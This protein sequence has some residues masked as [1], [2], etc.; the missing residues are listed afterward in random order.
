MIKSQTI[1]A[2]LGLA[3]LAAGLMAGAAPSSAQTGNPAQDTP[4]DA[5]SRNL[6]SLSENPKSIVALMG[7]GKAALDLGDAQ[8][9]ITF[10]GRAEEQAPR[11][12]RV[13]MWLG[14][15]LVQ[16]Q[17]AQ[18]ALKFFAEAISLGVPEAEV[19]GA[20][21][22]AYDLLGDPR[23][24]QRDYRL[25]LQ[26]KPNAQVSRQLALSLAISGEREP[27]LRAIED[28]L[29]I[30]DRAAERTRAFVLALTGDSA[31]AARAVQAS[32]P[33]QSAALTPF[34]QRLPALSLSDRALAVHLGHFPSAAR[35]LPVPPS[36]SYASLDPDTVTRAGAPDSRQKALGGRSGSSTRTSVRLPVAPERS[37]KAAPKAEAPA[38]E[39]RKTTTSSGLA[40]AVRIAEQ[41]PAAPAAQS[42]EA[43]IGSGGPIKA[44]PSAVVQSAVPAPVP[45][46]PATALAANTLQ[47]SASPTTSSVPSAAP[48][49]TAQAVLQSAKAPATDV[50]AAPSAGFSLIPSPAPVEL[51][52]LQ[53]QQQPTSELT[54]VQQAPA[55]AA[56]RV[57]EKGASRLADIASLI[58]SLPEETEAQAPKPTPAAVPAKKTTAAPAETVTAA[59]KE[60]PAKTQLAAKTPIKTAAAKKEVAA[61]KKP[62]AKPVAPAEPKRIWVQVAGGADKAALPREF[63][64]L[65]TKAPK[66]LAARSAW[67]VPLK[68][69]NRLLVGPFKTDGEAQAFVNELK[70]ASLTGFAWT[71]DAGQKIEKLSAK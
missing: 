26:A 16:L 11:D 70:K 27:A 67:T 49:T 13:K 1:G 36:N 25:A 60:T 54:S 20:R 69:T 38:A 31:G 22:L 21:G 4:G 35:N 57:E 6:R 30:R 50:A 53:P 7:A 66:L 62:A 5:L 24:A 41:K 37:A 58:A 61:E 10:F 55:P 23:R 47:P 18:G 34:L 46:Q 33:A 48:M 45:Q 40:P 19:A 39:K 71:S 64:R 14:A 43:A 65:K 51:A 12:G 9:A 59:P 28:Q 29:L 2:R 52:S 42:A 8:A 44:P 3:L 56:A 32:M 15:S 68:A 17:Q 63:T